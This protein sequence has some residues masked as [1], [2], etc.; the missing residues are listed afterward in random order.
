MSELTK[1]ECDASGKLFGVKNDVIEFEIRRHVRSS[2]EM[3][4]RT[5]H[6]SLNVLSDKALNEPHMLKYVGVEEGEVVGASIGY[7]PTHGSIYHEYEERGNY[8]IE[9]YEDFF[10]FVEDEIL[11]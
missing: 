11:Y 7:N 3:S 4:E 9:Q 6:I 5:V 1:F 8:M 10:K 2:F